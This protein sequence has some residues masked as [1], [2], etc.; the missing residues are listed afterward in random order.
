MN[1][2]RTQWLLLFALL[3]ALLLSSPVRAQ[4]A[5]RTQEITGDLPPG[6]YEWYTLPDLHAGQTLY[7]YMEN[8]G[9]NLD[10]VV[11]LLGPDHDPQVFLRAYQ[12]AITQAVAAG[13][14]P[15]VAVAQ[16]RDD[17]TLR[18][19]D[20]SGPGLTAVFSYEVPQDGDYRLI[21]AGS[22][23]QQGVTN[24]GAYRL[25]VGLDAPEVLEGET[26]GE[27]SEIA[28]LDEADS[29]HGLAVEARTGSLSAA[30]PPVRL[31]LLPLE[32]GD[33]L[34]AY[35]E[36]T[37]GDLRP[38]LTLRNYAGK[39]IAIGNAEGQTITATLQYTTSEDTESNYTLALS[40]CCAGAPTSG[41]YRL[42]L[43]VNEPAVLSGDAP[44]TT[45]AVA[46]APIPVQIG[47]KI[48]QI[49]EVNQAAEYMNVVANV[50]FRWQDPSLAFNPDDCDCTFRVYTDAQFNDFLKATN[51]LWP[52]FFFANQQ[53]NRWTQNRAAIIYQDGSAAYFERFSTN[54]HIDF[55]FHQYPFDTQTFYVQS[56]LLFP[57]TQFVYTGLPGYTGIDPNHGEDEFILGPITTA[58]TT[59]TSGTGGTASRFTMSF[60]APRHMEYYILQIFLPIL[61]IITV[62]YVTFFLKDYGRRIEVASANLL[63]FIAFSFSLSD[64]YPHLGYVTFMDAVMTT[65][66][67]INALVVIYNVWL[68]RL[69]LQGRGDFAERVDNYLDW[70]YPLAYLIAGLILYYLYFVRAGGYF[71][72]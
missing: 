33:V 49:T 68:R 56:D 65:T 41:D 63:L 24:S 13:E 34:T 67:F 58:I 14:D 50:F 43:G 39:P 25:L 40:P 38:T 29:A 18:W 45:A 54:L 53:G 55:D 32:P 66:F 20:D 2:H 12:D 10:P 21:A 3:F 22:L 59:T 57:D 42:L 27:A 37:S 71:E 36:A 48:E 17:Y 30:Q 61:L 44:T 23:A 62:S 69:E 5:P 60:E 31:T 11:G 16:A 9:G 7:I 64:N 6:D 1:L 47:V 28:F 51:S 26:Q 15:L 4:D 35:A 19:D 70:L 46:V 52:S 72:L 8:T